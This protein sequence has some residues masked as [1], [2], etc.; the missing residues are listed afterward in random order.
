[1]MRLVVSE[2]LTWGVWRGGLES[3]FGFASERF[4]VE[5]GLGY[6]RARYYDPAIGRWM[7]KDPSGFVDGLNLYA[8]VANSPINHV[9]ASGLSSSDWDTWVLRTLFPDVED[10]PVENPNTPTDSFMNGITYGPYFGG[11]AQGEG[12]DVSTDHF[13]SLPPYQKFAVFH[14][15]DMIRR[16]GDGFSLMDVA[17]VFAFAHSSPAAAVDFY[18]TVGGLTVDLIGDSAVAVGEW[19]ASS[20]GAAAGFGYDGGI[21][22]SLTS[23]NYYAPP[24]PPPGGGGAFA[25]GGVL[26]NRAVDFVGELSSISGVKVDDISGQVILLGESD[27]SGSIPDLRV[28]DFVTAVRAVFS[29][30]E[31]PGVTI[32]PQP[33]F[34]SD[35]SVPQLVHLFAGLEDTDMGWVLFEADRVMKTLAA[36]KD[37]VSE[38]PVTSSVPGYESMLQRWV[39][40]KASSGSSRF[41]FVPSE[42]KLVRSAEGGQL[43][44]RSDFRQAPD[45]RQSGRKRRLSTPMRRS[46]PIGLPRTTKRSRKR[47]TRSTTIRNET[48]GGEQGSPVA[49]LSAIGAGGGG[50]R[51]CPLLCTTTTFPST[52]LGSART[53]FRSRTHRWKQKTV[54]NSR[55][56]TDGSQTVTITVT[57]G[58]TLETPNAYLPDHAGA[59]EHPG[60]RGAQRPTGRRS[61]SNGTWELIR[62]WPSRWI[63]A[64]WTAWNREPISTCSTSPRAAFRLG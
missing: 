7:S 58:V 5:T 44:L 52:S 43:R 29:S 36:E 15:K 37:N 10:G 19:F 57:G 16:G 11:N 49:D 22:N 2:E 64:T 9:D 8:Y 28:D 63:R 42:M 14:D 26:L 40:A 48:V 18:K 23:R 55:S 34:E 20:S 31:Y 3:R 32:D 62:P 17:K 12:V 47:S 50:D 41:W 60:R 59:A 61:L 21:V 35:A 45:G 39:D 6:L 54:Q 38:A 1:M 30:A 25:V 46:S 4:E 56:Y 13:R 27:V 53:T 51:I 33:G 24:P